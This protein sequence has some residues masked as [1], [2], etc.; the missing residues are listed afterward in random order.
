MCLEV[1]KYR[2]IVRLRHAYGDMQKSLRRY[3]YH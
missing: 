1:L 3:T 2:L